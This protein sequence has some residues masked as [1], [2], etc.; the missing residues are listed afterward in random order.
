MKNKV[1][2]TPENALTRLQDL[3]SRSEHSEGELREKMWQW[4]I[5]PEDAT[6][7]IVR[8]RE[9]KFV[10][11]RRFASAYC[12]Q[13]LFFSHWGKKKIALSLAAK[14][15]DRAIISETL[16]E[17]DPVDYQDILLAA[18]RTRARQ[19]KEGNT[20]EGR[21][22]L[23]R[24]MLS[25]GFESQLIGMI[26]RNPGYGISEKPAICNLSS[27]MRSLR[28]GACRRRKTSVPAMHGLD[29]PPPLPYFAGES[30]CAPHGGSKNRQGGCNVPLRK[31][32][33]IRLAHSES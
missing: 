29:A 11:D 25:R 17:I 8:L 2:L 10:D 27:G 5:K 19:I 20:Y 24:A 9:D 4:G 31:R 18:M 30:V 13:K 16:A 22:R 26:I 3:C 12:R 33:R 32:Q 7:I 28:S 6:K 21:T 23:Y 14:R 15:V 1:Q